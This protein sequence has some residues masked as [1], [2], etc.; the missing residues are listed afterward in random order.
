MSN[1]PI[2]QLKSLRLNVDPAV[3]DQ[4]LAAIDSALATRPNPGRSRRW[5]LGVVAAT[6]IVGPV[7]G[8]AAEQAVPGDLLYPVKVGLEPVRELFDS[9]VVADHRV[10]ELDELV[11][12]GAEDEIIDRQ[13]DIARDALVDVDAPQLETRFDRLVDRIESERVTDAPVTDE[14]EPVTPP[15]TDAPPSDEPTD[16]IDTPVTDG[17]TTTTETTAAPRDSATTTEAVTDGAGDRPR[18]G[19]G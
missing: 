11:T 5:I 12:T 8:L 7:A 2:E 9:N 10:E 19:D 16:R 6:L 17:P 4:D 18:D 13:V 3:R 1:D 14:P 15:G